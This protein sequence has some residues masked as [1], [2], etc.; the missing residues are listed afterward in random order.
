M[1][2]MVT[3]VVKDLKVNLVIRVSDDMEHDKCMQVFTVLCQY[4]TTAAVPA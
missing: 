2:M 3:R 4:P 1:L